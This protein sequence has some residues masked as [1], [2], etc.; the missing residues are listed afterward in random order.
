I[1]DLKILRQSTRRSCGWRTTK[2]D[3]MRQRDGCT[4]GGCAIDDSG[5]REGRSKI[6]ARWRKGRLLLARKKECSVF[7]RLRERERG[8]ISSPEIIIRLY[9]LLTELEG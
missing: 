3:A 6:R 8:V 9:L 2:I 1:Q 5:A 4:C 7:G